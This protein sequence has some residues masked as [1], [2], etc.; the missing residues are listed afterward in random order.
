MSLAFIYNV[1]DGCELLEASL[2]NAKNNNVDTN[3]VV[4]QDVSYYGKKINTYDINEVISYLE[5][6][7]LIDKSIKYNPVTVCA[8][9]KEAKKIESHKYLLG[10]DYV[11]EK[12]IEY[13]APRAIDEF[14]IKEEFEHAFN[15][16][17]D[18]DYLRAF[19]P[20][21]TY[22]DIDRKDVVSTDSVNS[23][24]MY[25]TLYADDP[26][27]GHFEKRYGRTIGIKGKYTEPQLY[28]D[29][30]VKYGVRRDVFFDKINMHH[31]R[32]ARLEL[33]TKLEN[34]TIINRSGM[35]KQIK[36]I[37]ALRSKAEKV[38]N[39]FDI[40]IEKFKRLFLNKE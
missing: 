31:Y 39:I 16:V 7:K 18:N 8:T 28:I 27:L 3:I 25:K 32:L 24:V 5:K 2:K 40:D 14:F 21:Q 30:V 33:N 12:R 38:E 34:S 15:V 37:E 6:E 4:Y 13:F 17:K 35:S 36:S 10:L 26:E 22:C 23:I 1:F 20:I 29:E 9:N 11:K 19:C